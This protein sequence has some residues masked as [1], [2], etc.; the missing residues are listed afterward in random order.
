MNL[1]PTLTDELVHIRPL[2]SSDRELLYRVA[3]NP[4]LWDQHPAKRY[5]REVFDRFFEESLKT[6]AALTIEDRTTGKV[7]GSSRY[8]V[9]EENDRV[10]EIGWSYLDQSY[11]GG[12]YNGAVKRLMID[13]ALREFDHVVLIIAAENFRS[14]RA[15]AKIGARRLEPEEMPEIPGMAP[16]KLRYL[17]SGK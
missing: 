5:R 11:W 6:G 16:D 1:Q 15:A 2:R 7:I 3:Q 17:I 4:V 13:H 12:T 8:K 14:Q 10:I 9:F